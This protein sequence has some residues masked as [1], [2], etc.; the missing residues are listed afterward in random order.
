MHA[1][2]IDFY[3]QA[4]RTPR[5]SRPPLR[6]LYLDGAAPAL[7][8]RYV[9]K[10]IL[11]ANSLA[12]IFG[13]PGSGKTFFAIDAA[14]HVA[15][16]LEWRGRRVRQGLVAY[17][18]PEG[19]ASALNRAIAWCDANQVG[20]GLPFVIGPDGLSLRSDVDRVLDWIGEAETTTVEGL[21]LLVIDTLSRAFG[22]AD[23]N[24]SD[25]MGGFIAC[26]D[27]LRE[28]TG[29]CI[30]LVHHSGKDASKGARGSSLLQAAADTVIEVSDR[31]ATVAKQR[32]GETGAAYS[33][34]LEVIE[35]GKDE[36]GDP[37]TTCVAV[38][39]DAAPRPRGQ[40]LTP[41]ERNA[42]DALLE[43]LADGELRRDAPAALLIEG[44]RM[45]QFVALIADW[46]TRAYARMGTDVDQQAKQKRFRRAVDG[47]QAKQRIEIFEDYA[48]T[49]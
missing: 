32:D 8:A 44:A 43:V 34:N 17:L 27:Y 2:A 29:A 25:A 3:E 10:G 41:S 40:M 48:W 26:C 23:E 9:I 47:L 11:P 30:A 49:P 35:L 12:V 20:R 42:F 37:V 16:R 36:D 15:A 4:P 33:F 6:S 5:E 1:D 19:P 39:S 28:Q 18:A 22:A 45:G 24:A 31:V 13:P 38:P 46:R 14:M 7:D 21:R